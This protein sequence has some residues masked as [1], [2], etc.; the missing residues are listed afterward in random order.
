[1]FAVFSAIASTTLFS[2]VGVLWKRLRD[3]DIGTLGVL[4]IGII[5]VPFWIIV[6]GIL[7]YQ[8][9]LPVLSSSYLYILVLWVV[10]A[11]LVNWVGTYLFKYRTL[12]ELRVYETLA[13][14]ILGIATDILFFKSQFSPYMVLATTLL[15]LSGLILTK[16]IP[17]DRI[18]SE[19]SLKRLLPLLLLGAVLQ[20]FNIAIFKIALSHQP[21]P[22]WHSI[23][24]ESILYAFFF[25][26]GFKNIKSGI[27]VK[28]IGLSESI[29]IGLL[30]FVGTVF[31]IFMIRDFSVSLNVV[32]SIIPVVIYSLY[33]IQSKKI[34][35]SLQSALAFLLLIIGL[36]VAKL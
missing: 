35:L 16:G 33:D 22:L 12:T 30:L 17:P 15:F 5:S 7:Y 26:V 10:G 21:N 13:A 9:I 20:V 4:C 25:F 31:Q 3:R 28:K 29:L 19:I 27:Q 23:F 14:I 6:A 32:L 18:R 1:M 2:G 36:L 8:N 34:R 24:G 11:F